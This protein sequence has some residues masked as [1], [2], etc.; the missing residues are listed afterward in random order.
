MFP[1]EPECRF[2]LIPVNDKLPTGK[3][4][5]KTH[6]EQVREWPGFS[7]EIAD[8]FNSNPDLFFYLAHKGMFKV[9]VRLHKSR[10]KAEHPGREPRRTGEQDTVVPL[11]QHDD[12]R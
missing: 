8:I 12:G 7:A 4:C 3:I 6:H 10:D 2:D 1:V 5:S 11:H 9:F